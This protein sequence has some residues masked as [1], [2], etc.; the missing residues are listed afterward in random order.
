M[1]D[2]HDRIAKTLGWS[3]RDV[4]SMSMQSL[5]EL[6]RPVDPDLAREMDYVIQSGA[7]VRG[8]AVKPK[9][10]HH[11]T[12]ARTKIW[13]RKD[14]KAPGALEPLKYDWEFVRVATTDEV[15]RWLEIYRRDHPGVVFV[16]SRA[17]PRAKKGPK[18]IRGPGSEY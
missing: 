12:V 5:R 8:S 18:I 1:S 17:K 4:Q 2:L 3:T 11:A 7:Y 10:R 9:S 13:S 15:D 16:A 14:W 6:V